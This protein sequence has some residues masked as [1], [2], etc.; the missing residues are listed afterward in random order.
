MVL[1]MG[2]M[3]CLLFVTLLYSV[4]SS[5]DV[6]ERKESLEHSHHYYF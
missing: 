4:D 2:G 1:K 5:E 3:S 6:I